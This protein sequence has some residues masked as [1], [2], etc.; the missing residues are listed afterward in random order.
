MFSRC[1]FNH[2][3]IKAIES[4]IILLMRYRATEQTGKI[5]I[6]NRTKCQIE[7]K[8]YEYGA[9]YNGEDRMISKV[10]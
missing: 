3:P 10:Y 4:L 1:L 2:F 8:S 5:F 7:L 9:I 6:E